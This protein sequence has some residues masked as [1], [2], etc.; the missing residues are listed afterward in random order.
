MTAK[1]DKDGDLT[2]E[3]VIGKVSHFSEKGVSKIEY[4][5]FDKE[6]NVG[7]Y[8]RIVHFDNYTSPKFELTE[9]L[10]Y[11]TND[12]ITLSDRLMAKDMITGDISDK[13]K[14][15]SSN[16]IQNKKGVYQVTVSV[17]NQFGD[18]VRENLGKY[19]REF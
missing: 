18:Y 1:D 4:V 13:I 5:V 2:D 3:I 19:R 11:R 6:N 9:P 17:K 10:M 14:F 15:E 16:V 7:K 12:K 8:E